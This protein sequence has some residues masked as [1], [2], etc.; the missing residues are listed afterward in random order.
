MGESVAYVTL[1][2]ASSWSGLPPHSSRTGY[3]AVHVQNMC[4]LLSEK[5]AETMHRRRHMFIAADFHAEL[6]RFIDVD[7]KHKKRKG[8]EVDAVGS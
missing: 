1:L 4:T 6:A 2:A 8:P 3:A 7:D 5:H